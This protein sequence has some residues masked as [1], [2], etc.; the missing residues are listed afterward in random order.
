MLSRATG[1]LG[2]AAHAP[3]RA[4]ATFALQN[5]VF[6]APKP[7]SGTTIGVLF[8]QSTI[9]RWKSLHR[10]VHAP[11]RAGESV[12]DNVH[13]L[14]RRRIFRSPERG[15]PAPIQETGTTSG[16]LRGRSTIWRW[17]RLHRR[18][19]APP[20][21]VEALTEFST[22]GHAAACVRHTRPRS[23]QTPE[24][25]VASL[26]SCVIPYRQSARHVI[27]PRGKK[28]KKKRKNF[29]RSYMRLAHAICHLSLH[30]LATSACHVKKKKKKKEE[31]KFW[32]GG[33]GLLYGPN[34]S[35]R[36]LWPRLE[37]K[38]S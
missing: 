17:K 9:W 3:P 23:W 16:L 2:L 5:T 27:M 22:R 37:A 21:A 8:G 25:R 12:G 15:F 20:R 13:A 18:P 14:Q 10:S 4:A 33:T 34:S 38:F 32:G 24:P 35:S 19:N 6:W 30:G 28:K 7:Q 29:G 36:P 1:V 11:P 26:C 31:E